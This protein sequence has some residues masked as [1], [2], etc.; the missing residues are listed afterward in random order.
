MGEKVTTGL[1]FVFS[2]IA[3]GIATTIPQPLVESP[4]GGASWPKFVLAIIF[5]GSGIHLVKLLLRKKEV[6]E[7]LAREAEEARRR[8]EEETGERRVFSLIIFGVIVSFLYIFSLRWIGFP[9]ATPLFMAI[10]MYGT[11]YRKKIT[12]AIVPLS[13][14]AVFLFLFVKATYIPLPRGYGI[15]RAISYLIY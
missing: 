5:F 7:R 12:L 3:Y 9:C 8:E 14:V 13:T 11:G 15:F 10:F 4:L 1:M 2:I 6:E